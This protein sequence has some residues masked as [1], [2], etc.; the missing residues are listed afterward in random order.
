[1]ADGGGQGQPAL[2]F[3][4]VDEGAQPS[5]DLA[6]LELHRLAVV[7]VGVEATGADEVGAALGAQLRAHLGREG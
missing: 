3:H 5:V 6:Q 2:R 1:M 4:L 7:R